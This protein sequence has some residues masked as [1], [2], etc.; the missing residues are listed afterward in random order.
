MPQ[1]AMCLLVAVPLGA[2]MVTSSRI[3]ESWVDSTASAHRLQLQASVW[4]AAERLHAVPPCHIAIH[5]ADALE[6]DLRGFSDSLLKAGIGRD[7]DAFNCLVYS[8]AVPWFA[9]VEDGA[10]R[11]YADVEPRVSAGAVLEPRKAGSLHLIYPAE[12]PSD[13]QLCRL[14]VSSTG[15]VDQDGCG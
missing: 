14:V 5:S 6:P 9:T 7:S 11:A 10:A 4:V 13:A 3:V 12:V 8:G 2:W 1:V 15:V